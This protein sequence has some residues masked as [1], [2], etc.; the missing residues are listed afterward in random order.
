LHCDRA[1]RVYAVTANAPGLLELSAAAADCRESVDDDPS[2]ARAVSGDAVSVVH[3]VAGLLLHAHRPELAGRE[4]LHLLEI[5]N[6]ATAG[7]L[8]SL[9][10][11]TGRRNLA[12]FGDT[13]AAPARTQRIT[14][15]SVGPHIVELSYVPNLDDVEAAA[16]L[17]SIRII[18]DVVAEVD[19]ARADRER[20]LT[21]WPV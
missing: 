21:L 19:S 7:W 18:A 5:S 4:L 16:A 14:L 17:N 1:Q 10:V 6:A 15:S 9:D 2:S 20:S 11:G 12:H 13:K 8:T 3:D